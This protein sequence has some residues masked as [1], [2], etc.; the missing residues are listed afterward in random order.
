MVLLLLADGFEDMEAVAVLDILRRAGLTLR[1][2]GVRGLSVT[3]ARGMTVLADMPLEDVN[4]SEVEMVV[5]PG[6]VPGVLN[7]RN[8][9]V[10]A[11]L[12]DADTRGLWLAAICAAPVILAEEGLLRGRRAIGYPGTEADLVRHGARIQPDAHVVRDGRFITAS[13]AGHAMDFALKLA[14]VLRGFPAAE[15]VR[16]AIVFDPPVHALT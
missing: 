14:E 2:V 16:R 3:S 6:G 12:H 5:L 10:R 8:P 1:T 9:E 15:A 11:L 7:L 4:L 13:G